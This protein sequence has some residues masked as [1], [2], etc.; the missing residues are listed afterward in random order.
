[1]SDE[2]KPTQTVGEWLRSL[3]PGGT[4][5]EVVPPPFPPP[6]AELNAPSGTGQSLP[7]RGD[8]S[9]EPQQV[10]SLAWFHRRASLQLAKQCVGFA[11]S[12]LVALLSMEMD[13]WAQRF[14]GWQANFVSNLFWFLGV[15][16][17]GGLLG[18]GMAL[19]FWC[20]GYRRARRELVEY[21]DKPAAYIMLHSTVVGSK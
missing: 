4:R 11:V 5:I 10:L 2:N 9:P 21:S 14:H 16:S 8:P 15:I 7:N 12:A 13:T 6:P 3:P 19:W 18:F 1:M 20:S 17:I